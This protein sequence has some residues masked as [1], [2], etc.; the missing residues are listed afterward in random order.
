MFSKKSKILL[1][2]LV[3]VA[4]CMCWWQ[5]RGRHILDNTRGLATMSKLKAI[6]HAASEFKDKYDTFPGHLHEAV[7]PS[8]SNVTEK[9]DFN[10]A[11]W[12]QL[13]DAGFLR[14]YS[15]PIRSNIGGVIIAKDIDDK[16]FPAGMRPEGANLKG[17]SLLIVTERIET[18]DYTFKTSDAF[19]LTPSQ[20]LRMDSNKF[21]DRKPDKGWIQA[22]GTKDC[23]IKE[24][25]AYVYNVKF[26]EP[27]CGIIFT[28]GPWNK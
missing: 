8:D 16:T 2:L 15:F 18:S 13:R 11:F 14:E 6:E 26:D 27:V 3:T 12:A 1:A 23:F 21:D 22:F 7:T 5:I 28:F 24:D 4:L 19:P 10:T 20:A 25:G 9:P 17:V